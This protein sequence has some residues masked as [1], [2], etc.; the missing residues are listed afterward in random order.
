MLFIIHTLFPKTASSLDSAA[1]LMIYYGAEKSVDLE[2]VI[3]GGLIARY[4]P[5]RDRET[6]ITALVLTK[7]GEQ[8]LGDIHKKQ[9]ADAATR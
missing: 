1:G 6:A 9:A 3:S 8:V 5:K 2:G 7:L 4:D